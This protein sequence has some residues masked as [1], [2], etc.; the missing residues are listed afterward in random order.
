MLFVLQNV[1]VFA[2]L[3]LLNVALALAGM[4]KFKHKS[5]MEV[6]WMISLFVAAF[7]QV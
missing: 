6:I 4:L 1:F 3:C 5:G 7:C 2:A